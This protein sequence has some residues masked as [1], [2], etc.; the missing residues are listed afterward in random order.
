LGIFVPPVCLFRLHEHFSHTSSRPKCDMFVFFFVLGTVKGGTQ[1]QPFTNIGR[2]SS[3]FTSS[4]KLHHNTE[5][6][7]TVVAVN[8]AGLRTVS[9][10]QPVYVD[11][12]PPEFE[13]LYDGTTHGKTWP[14]IAE[15]INAGIFE[16]FRASLKT[17]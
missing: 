12:T 9:H 16:L 3:G 11:L 1:L 7:V 13:Y 2:C 6:H 5:V 14:Y 10:S 4:L 8:G 17:C 15:L